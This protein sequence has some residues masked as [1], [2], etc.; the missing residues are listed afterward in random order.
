MFRLIYHQNIL[1]IIYEKLSLTNYQNIEKLNNI[2]KIVTL[3]DSP[4]IKNIII[5]G[6]YTQLSDSYISIIRALAHAAFKNNH[7]IT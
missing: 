5:I 6:K 7:K 1:P 2:K 3:M 4:N